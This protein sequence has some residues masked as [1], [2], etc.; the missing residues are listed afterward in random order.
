MPAK[1]K[2]KSFVPGTH[3]FIPY[4]G[5]VHEVVVE[6]GASGKDFA[7]VY[8]RF[9]NPPVPTVGKR[10]VNPRWV[11]K[12]RCF[13]EPKYAL[14]DAMKW[15]RASIKDL[16]RNVRYYRKRLSEVRATKKAYSD[17]YKEDWTD[18]P[19]T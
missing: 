8:V 10:F 19:E 18:G 15:Y 1:G 17:A 14:N 16:E 4:C 9:L 5:R 7:W 12:N 2:P 11:S 13:T 6:E 3:L